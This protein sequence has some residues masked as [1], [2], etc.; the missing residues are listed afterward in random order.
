MDVEE[1]DTHQEHESEQLI[2][3]HQEREVEAMVGIEEDDEE[4]VVEEQDPV[5]GKPAKMWPDMDT[6]L[7][8]R[9]QKKV[10]A[11]R[12]TYEDVVNMYDTAMAS[13][14][15]DDIF[16]YMADLEVGDPRF[17]SA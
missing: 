6:A 17:S 1:D 5:D 8:D 7:L 9:C 14:Y 13:E 11:L 10:E 4:D 12:E 3:L 16:E 2:D 15:A